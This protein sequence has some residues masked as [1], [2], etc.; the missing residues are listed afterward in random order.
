MSCLAWSVEQPICVST[1]SHAKSRAKDQGCSIS[2][3]ASSLVLSSPFVR[4]LQGPVDVP[5]CICISLL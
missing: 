1:Q 5:E 2:A 4:F 3:P